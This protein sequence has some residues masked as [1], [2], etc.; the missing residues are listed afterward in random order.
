MSIVN[1]LCLLRENC[2]LE[3]VEER[4][5]FHRLL[6]PLMTHW[7]HF[8]HND[9]FIKK[10]IQFLL[11]QA[12]K[13]G[14]NDVVQKFLDRGL[15]PNVVAPQTGDS[16]LHLALANDQG[17]AAKLLL[18]RGANLNFVDAT[19]STP[20]HVICARP[21]DQWHRAEMLFELSDEKYRP[22][23]ID[24]QDKLGKTPLLVAVVSKNL[25]VAKLL[26]KK[27]VDPKLADINGVDPRD[28]ISLNEDLAR[29]LS[30]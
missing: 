4:R 6:R 19:G 2:N 11:M 10:E 22:L 26:L 7:S 9:T 14:C 25:K 1:T 29:M 28:I 27:G 13:F 12:S 17:F 16:P 30:D 8:N 15:D 20:L 23:E 18:Q 21:D 3:S 24:A 5:K